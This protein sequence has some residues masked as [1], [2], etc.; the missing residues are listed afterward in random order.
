M[1][2]VKLRVLESHKTL[3]RKALQREHFSARNTAFLSSAAATSSST[4]A[5]AAPSAANSAA[6]SAAPSR[7][8]SRVPSPSFGATAANDDQL[9]GLSFSQ[10]DDAG[11]AAAGAGDEDVG[12]LGNAEIDV[13]IEA[14]LDRKRSSIASREQALTAFNRILRNDYVPE[15]VEERLEELLAAFVKSVRTEASD[16]EAVLACAAVALAAITTALPTVYDETAA[17]LQRSARDSA[18]YAVKAAALHALGAVTFFTGGDANVEEVMAFLLE[19]VESDGRYA[20][21]PDDP[22]TVRAAA[23]EWALLATECDDLE[24]LSAAAVEAFL[25]QLDSE[26]VGV[27]TSCGEALALLYEKSYTPLEEGEEL[28]EEYRN[29]EESTGGGDVLV[30]RY[31]A[32][33]NTP[34]VLRKTEE[35]ASASGRHVHR[36]ARRQLHQAFSAISHTI[37]HPQ[38]GPFYSTAID[39]ETGAPYGNRKTMRVS[40]EASDAEVLLDRWWK[41]V[42]LQAIRRHLLGG[43]PTHM[44]R[45]NEALQECLP[46]RPVDRGSYKKSRAVE[47]Q[48]DIA[49]K[50]NMMQDE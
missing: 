2:E 28:P 33:R 11:A 18:S 1:R 9:Q 42:R 5:S 43:F 31:D 21:A 35:L 36:T 10:L 41:W 45:G 27:Q 4:T 12:T 38:H 19:I 6:N 47:K 22:D 15:P 50:K 24:E 39:H 44:A 7:V 14:I 46:A 8:G 25:E 40:G 3:S 23:D 34:L 13:V 16:R 49:R 48:R 32:Y 30:K 17:Q 20:N 29:G 26:D 37:A